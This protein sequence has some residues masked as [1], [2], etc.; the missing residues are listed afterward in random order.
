MANCR[1]C[2]SSK[3]TKRAAGLFSCPHCGV[4]PGGAGYD[5]GGIAPPPIE[6][7][8]LTHVEPIDTRRTI[9]TRTKGL[10]VRTKVDAARL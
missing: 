5:R 4:Q 1:K 3:I 6:T 7:Q 10:L 9:Y 2:G 8:E